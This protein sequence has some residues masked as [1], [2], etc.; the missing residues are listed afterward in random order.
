MGEAKIIRVRLH[1]YAD[2]PIG[3]IWQCGDRS[4]EVSSGYYREAEAFRAAGRLEER[5][6]AGMLP[7]SSQGLRITW[8]DFCQRYET[9]WLDRLSYGSR[10]GW[11]DA[12]RHFEEICDPQFLSDVD[13]AMLSQFRSSL[14]RKV[15]PTSARSYYAA[16]RAGLGWAE[17]V[18]LLNQVPR[19]RHRKTGKRVATMRSRVITA[20]E[21]DRLILKL[22]LDSEGQKRGDAKAFERFATGL[23]FSGLRIDELNRLRWEPSYPLHVRFEGKLPMIV[24]LGAQKN[25][26]D[27]YLPAPR[28]FWQLVDRPGVARSGHVFPIAGRWG[29]QMAT[30]TIGREISDAGK[31]AGVV[32]DPRSQKCATAHDLRA[33]YL[34]RMAPLLQANQLQSLARHSDPKTTSQFYIRH[35]AEELAKAAGW[36]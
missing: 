18:D 8:A 23:W 5:L 30:R 25:A 24:F 35:E 2:R 13:K 16:L 12:K 20:E 33:S 34:T 15:A 1:R 27:T 6:A 14:E 32:V 7:G 22:R 3:L 28:E 17:S 21:F 9:E 10:R 29:N 11:K 4:G 26:S 36:T 19:I 31:L